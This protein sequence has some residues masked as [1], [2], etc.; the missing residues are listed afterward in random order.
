MKGRDD[1]TNISVKIKYRLFSIILLCVSVILISVLCVKYIDK[2]IPNNINIFKNEIK[3][4]D[5]NLPLT[6]EISSNSV[7]SI[8]FN[9]PISFHAG[10]VGAYSLDIKLFGLFDLKTVTINVVE[11]QQLIPCGIPI[12]IYMKT[13]G[14]LVVNTGN[15]INN[16]GI[17]VCPAD[18]KLK[19]GD[20]ITT[21][22]SVPVLTKND[23]IAE[24]NKS[25][26][27]NIVL[28]LIRN[29]ESIEVRILPVKDASGEYKIGTW[30]RD[31]A[32][33]IGTLTYIDANNNFGALGHG[34]SDVDVGQL[35]KLDAG[36]LYKAKVVSIVKGKAGSPGEFVGTIDYN[37]KNQIGEITSNTSSGIFG[38]ISNQV[39]ADYN[40]E[41]MDIGYKYEVH[42]GSA[43]IRTYV[44]NAIKD[45]EVEI[46]DSDSASNSDGKN[47]TFKV[48]DPELLA[49]TNGIVQGMS[50]S[51]II[52]DNKIIGAVTHVF[53][54]DSTMGY[55][56][57]IENMLNK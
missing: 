8:N 46:L 41:P 45:Y 16:D 30:I 6:G 19:A 3:T 20:Y 4:L 17:S 52:Q 25:G 33:G 54:D 47:I 27:Q 11:E 40:L 23:L 21:I 39:I 51:P 37:A 13:D 9:N 49:I 44:E 22:N 53:V 7:T 35:L 12:G 48:T 32:Q 24:I 14:L 42:K 38:T 26:D 57:F 34:I 43:K 10:D 2:K 36:L 15:V 29:N 18:G 56:I 50:G 1:M 31:D 28:G 55:G 5:F